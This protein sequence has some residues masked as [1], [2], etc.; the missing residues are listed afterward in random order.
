MYIYKYEIYTRTIC[1]IYIY[2]GDARTHS[3]K[4]RNRLNIQEMVKSNVQLVNIYMFP[5]LCIP[6]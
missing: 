5:M 3:L 4:D 2:N 6:K 1:I